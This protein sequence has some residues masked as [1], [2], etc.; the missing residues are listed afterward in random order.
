M[1]YKPSK[2]LQQAVETS[3]SEICKARGAEIGWRRFW[4]L[5]GMMVGEAQGEVVRGLEPDL[6][7]EG[8][9]AVVEGRKLFGLVKEHE[10]AC[11]TQITKEQ[12]NPDVD[13]ILIALLSNSTLLARQHQ[14]LLE[15]NLKRVPQEVIVT[16]LENIHERMVNFRSA[17][18]EVRD[19]IRLLKRDEDEDEE[20]PVPG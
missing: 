12:R 3:V 4:M 13:S 18:S 6:A 19:L 20:V 14:D 15:E 7:I 16:R 10:K 9:L 17:D 11:I 2:E 1:S 8:E 5:I